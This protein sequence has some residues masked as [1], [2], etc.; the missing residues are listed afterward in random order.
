MDLVLPTKAYELALMRRPIIA[1]DTPA[2]RWMFRPESIALC[3]P[4][5]V[6]QYAE[7][8]V[9]LYHSPSKRAEMVKNAE[10]DNRKF[11]W[12]IMAARYQRLLLQLSGKG[13]TESTA[14]RKS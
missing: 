1:C 11:C 14:G 5:N 12:E 6:D 8:I 10:E 4:S 9:E 2:I 7:R 13:A 3:E